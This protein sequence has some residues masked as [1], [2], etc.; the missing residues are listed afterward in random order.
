LEDKYNQK[1]KDMDTRNIEL[2]DSLKRLTTGL[3]TM[4]NENSQ[5]KDHNKYL[6]LKIQ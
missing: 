5:L 1:Y 3:E 6:E 4:E 2:V